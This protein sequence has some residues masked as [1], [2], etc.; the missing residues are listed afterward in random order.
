[1]PSGGGGGYGGG[2]YGGGGGGGEG[3]GYNAQFS[4]FDMVSTGSTCDFATSPRL[5]LVGGVDVVG[6]IA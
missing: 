4:N 3:L 2:Y 1:M 6:M 5:V